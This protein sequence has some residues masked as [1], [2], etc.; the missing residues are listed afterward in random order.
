MGS[1]RSER[2]ALIHDDD[3]QNVNQKNRERSR[4]QLSKL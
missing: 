1:Q 2:M 4:F 3:V